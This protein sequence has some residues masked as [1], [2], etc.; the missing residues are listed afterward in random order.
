MKT[1]EKENSL[2]MK[3]S[4]PKLV[5]TIRESG[6]ESLSPDDINSLGIEWKD[7][8]MSFNDAGEADLEGSSRIKLRT[9]ADPKTVLSPL[10]HGF[11]GFIGFLFGVLVVLSV[12]GIICCKMYP[13]LNLTNKNMIL[14]SLFI[15]V[16][17]GISLNEFRT[18]SAAK[19]YMTE[20]VKG[21]CISHE[22]SRQNF[23]SKRSV[24][25]YT[26]QDKVYRSSE[27]V[28]ANKGYA[29]LGEERELLISAENPRDIYDPKAGNARK[30]GG[31]VVGMIFIGI[32]VTILACV[33]I[34]G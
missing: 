15:V 6:V 20:R 34:N 18:A 28:F 33:F 5:E 1:E 16:G 26:Y 24:F 12:T 31:I 29:K 13:Q 23:K 11:V 2:K 25:E 30:I 7:G 10:N 22:H 8:H 27:N 14:M 3:I 19:K 32:T 17:L 9:A 21:K 4:D